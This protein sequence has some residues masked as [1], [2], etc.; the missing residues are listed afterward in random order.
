MEAQIVKWGGIAGAVSAILGLGVAANKIAEQRKLKKQEFQNLV[1]AK[2]D[3]MRVKQDEL[4]EKIDDTQE[5]IGFVQMHELKRAHAFLMKQGWCS[6]EEK[7]G[8]L[9]LYDRYKN[10]KGRDSLI[11]S[12]ADDI[13]ALKPFPPE[14]PCPPCPSCP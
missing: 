12:F 10:I 3:E 14:S 5:D 4:S 13:K 2:L 9:L 6:D 7:G 8:L 11:D 1:L